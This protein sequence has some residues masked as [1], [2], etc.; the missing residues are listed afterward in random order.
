VIEEDVL[1]F[2]Q[3]SIPSV[4]TL[5]LLLLLRGSERAWSAEALV[6]ELRASALIVA[7]GLA[8]LAAAGLVLAQDGGTFSYRPAR[9]DLVALVDRVAA[10]YAEFPF[11]VTQA[12]LAAPHDKIRTFADAF[13]IKKK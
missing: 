9:A 1:H 12:I 5:E 10:A 4:W 3:T 8:S 6:R 13:R 7:N 11:A 2:I